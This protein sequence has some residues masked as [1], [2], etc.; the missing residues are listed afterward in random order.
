M[1]KILVLVFSLVAISAH[2]DAVAKP[3]EEA[4]PSDGE[5]LLAKVEAAEGC[6][7]AAKIAEDCAWG[8]SFDVQLAGIARTK[9]ESSF[10]KKAIKDDKGLYAKIRKRCEQVYSK[11]DGTLYRSAQAFCELS[12][13]QIFSNLYY[14]EENH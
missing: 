7:A 12:A 3:A 6:Y 1:I 8:S 11:K 2:A 13:A 4:C 5:K 9:C 14:E 10:M